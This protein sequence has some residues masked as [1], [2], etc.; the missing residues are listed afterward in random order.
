[1]TESALFSSDEWQISE[2]CILLAGGSNIFKLTNQTITIC[3]SSDRRIGSREFGISLR[4]CPSLFAYDF[5]QKSTSFLFWKLKSNQNEALNIFLRTFFLFSSG[6]SSMVVAAVVVRALVFDKIE[7]V[8]IF[9]CIILP[10]HNDRAIEKKSDPY[11]GLE[12]PDG[13]FPSLFLSL[14]NFQL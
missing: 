4:F 6:S 8:M 2:L 13:M 7:A 3:L 12:N 9:P 11:L 10:E 14:K 5:S 1:M